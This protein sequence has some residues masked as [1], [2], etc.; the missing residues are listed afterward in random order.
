ML[1][2][3]GILATSI[4]GLILVAATIVCLVLLLTAA[5]KNS[6]P[7]RLLP[8]IIIFGIASLFRIV[9]FTVAGVY[10]IN[11]DSI[12]NSSGAGIA[13]IVT[14]VIVAGKYTKCPPKATLLL[15]ISCILW[16]YFRF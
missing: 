2:N 6:K 13:L 16:S 15:L 12:A 14:A 7:K 10:L 5:F 3:N 8:W 9:A 11:D 1:D 4:I